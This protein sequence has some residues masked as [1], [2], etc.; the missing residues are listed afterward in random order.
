VGNDAVAEEGVDAMASSI[1]ELVGDYEVEWLVLFLERA[2]R[3]D[4]DDAVD[5][6]LL[7]SV[8]IGAEV[9]FGGQE[10]VAR[11]VT[12]EEGD[13]AAFELTEYVGIGGIAERSLLADFVDVGEPGHVVKATAADDSDFCALIYL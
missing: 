13:L 9:E 7:E 11:A 6:E 8:D 1:E 2:D 4:G 5:A 10:A 3:G 12:R